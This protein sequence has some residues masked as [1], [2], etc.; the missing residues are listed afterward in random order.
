MRLVLQLHSDKQTGVRQSEQLTAICRAIKAD[1]IYE[2]TILSEL[3]S[4]LF[5]VFQAC[6]RA[7]DEIPA[8]SIQA[9]SDLCEC[10]CGLM[11]SIFSKISSN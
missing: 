8:D 2:W 5:P 4:Q 1:Y 7:A 10:D 11:L 6:V 3:F 9:I